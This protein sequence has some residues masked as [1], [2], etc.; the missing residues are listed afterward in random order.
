VKQL[1]SEL[2]RFC[3]FQTHESRA[4]EIRAVQQ[5]L[6]ASIGMNASALVL[7]ADLNMDEEC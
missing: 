2:A 1:E 7:L 4:K 6:F 5:F 3:A